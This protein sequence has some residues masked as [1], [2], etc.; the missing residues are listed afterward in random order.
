M[1]CA[2]VLAI[3]C[4][5]AAPQAKAQVCIGDSLALVEV[6]Q[7]TGGPGWTSSTNWLT[8]PLATWQ[9]VT[10]SGNRVTSLSLPFNH[11]TGTLPYHLGFL[12]ELTNLSLQGNSLTGSIPAALVFLQKLTVLN[13]STNTFSGSI[14][15]TL[16]FTQ[17]LKSL[18]LS[19]NTLTGQVP[20]TLGLLSKLVS[21][22]LSRNQLSG[23]I[24]S[25]LGALA[26]LQDLSLANNKLTGTIPST[27]GGLNSVREVYLFDNKLS[28]ALP[29]AIGS[30][31]SVVIFNAANNRFTGAVPA[32]I[33][34]LQFLYFFNVEG[35]QIKD[36]PNLSASTSLLQLYVANNKL[37]FADIEPNIAMARGGNYAPQDSIGTNK[38]VNICAGQTLT[39]PNNYIEAS[40]NNTYT[41]FK[42]DF[43]FIGDPTADPVLTIPNVTAANSGLYSVQVA[44]SVA[45]DLLLYRKTVRVNVS[46]CATSMRALR[47]GDTKVYPVPFE[48][49]TTVEVAGEAAQV[50]VMDADGNVLETHTS[51]AQKSIQVG[52][53]LKKGTYIVQSLHGGKKEIVRIVKN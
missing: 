22:D 10:V 30:L 28:G 33:A 5:I 3:A 20:G 4:C 1:L 12:Q 40:P 7:A 32:T 34:S 53:T 37:T 52:G 29:N 39:L 9:G 27:I 24:P 6:Y 36:L 42:T 15:A 14:P 38:V 46:T 35:N 51:E 17:S 25:S 2:T 8:G 18:N 41:W 44:N 45:T 19:G 13:L 43:S 23:S 48:S 26:K 11:L 31:D 16:G 21:L 50:L 49:T 47:T